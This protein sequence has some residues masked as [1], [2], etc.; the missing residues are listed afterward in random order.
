[1]DTACDPFAAEILSDIRSRRPGAFRRLC[2]RCSAQRKFHQRDK[3]LSV[4]VDTDGVVWFCHH[5]S[6]AGGSRTAD[7]GTNRMDRGARYQRPDSAKAR[8]GI[9][10]RAWWG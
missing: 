7:G 6:L 10:R 2:P 9:G 1:M 3:C 8:L 4:T 5:C